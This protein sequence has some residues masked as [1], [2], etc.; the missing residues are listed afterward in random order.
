MNLSS[1]QK[2]I[3]FIASI[4]GSL[5]VIGTGGYNVYTW[6]DE[7][8]VT[9]DDLMIAVTDIR[10]GQIEESL[11]RYHDMGLKNLSDTQKHRYDKLITAERANEEHRKI[12]L[13]L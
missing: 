8:I 13:G 4:V 2:K 5:T 3:V 10:L 6:F 12:L 9:K 1:L 11:A 7:T